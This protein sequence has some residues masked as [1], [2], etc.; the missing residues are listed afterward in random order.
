ML[1]NISFIFIFK[2]L[3]MYISSIQHR[4]YLL[5]VMKFLFFLLKSSLRRSYGC[6]HDMIDRYGIS[7]L[8]ITTDM[9]HL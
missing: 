6:H 2:I 1:D 7:V 3:I 5:R 8:Q 9:F 4:Q